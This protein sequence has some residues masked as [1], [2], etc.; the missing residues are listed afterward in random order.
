MKENFL[1]WGR[2]FYAAFEA[3]VHGSAV[4]FV[5]FVTFDESIGQDGATNDLRNDGNL[6]YV[7]VVIAVTFK[8]LFDSSNIN[9]LVLMASIGSI[10]SYFLFVYSMGLIKE[11][12]I[13]D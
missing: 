12:E 7:C 4:F 3:I 1:T 13:F 10:A 2:Y 11:I 6:C 5:A 9:A 8:I